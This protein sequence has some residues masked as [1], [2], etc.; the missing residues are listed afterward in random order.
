MTARDLPNYRATTA[1]FSTTLLLMMPL[2]AGTA[3]TI[4]LK[5]FLGTYS[6]MQLS[7]RTNLY[8]HHKTHYDKE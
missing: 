2:R 6:K 4:R 3:L 8:C 7:G 1:K 5:S